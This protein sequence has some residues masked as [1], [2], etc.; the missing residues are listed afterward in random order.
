[1]KR[2][3]TV[4]FVLAACLGMGRTIANAASFTITE[5]K[6][7]KERIVTVTNP[8]FS[9]DFTTQGGRIR[10]FTTLPDKKNWTD[11]SPGIGGFF[12]DRDVRT[13]A[14]YTL[15]VKK[16]AMSVELLFANTDPLGIVWK[17]SFIVQDNSPS[18]AFSYALTS[19]SKKSFSYETMVRN[20]IFPAGNKVSKDSFLCFH[21]AEGIQQIRW[22]DLWR[23][24]KISDQ[25]IYN[26][27]YPWIALLDKTSKTGIVFSFEKVDK[28]YFWTKGNRATI[29][30]AFPKALM[31]PKKS[32]SFRGTISLV[33]G[34]DTV[35]YASQD[36]IAAMQPTSSE[37]TL[38]LLTLSR[39]SEPTKVRTMLYTPD[40]E[41]AINPIET[42]LPR[43]SDPSLPITIQIPWKVE[44]NKSFIASQELFSGKTKIA[45][46]ETPWS[47]SG[48]TLS[49]YRHPTRPL[50][51][52]RI[53]LH[54]LP[55]DIKRG[56][57]CFDS[58]FAETV[59]SISRLACDIGKEEQEWVRLGISAFSDLG[60]TSC[61]IVKSDFPGTIEVW[62]EEN[63][64][65][66]P[67]QTASLPKGTDT[68]FWMKIS[69]A[70]VPAGRYL[71]LLEVS[72]LEA[73][74]SQIEIDIKVWDVTLPKEKRLAC[75]FFHSSIESIFLY[76]YP[77]KPQT[78]WPVLWEKSLKILQDSGQNYFEFYPRAGVS[79]KLIT[80]AKREGNIP[81]LDFSK[82]DP[83]IRTARK[84]GC[85]NAVI[86]YIWQI[87]P[88]LPENFSSLSSQEQEEISF[89][90]LT[91][92]YNRL[93]YHGFSRIFYYHIDEL[94]PAKI[95]DVCA[96]M[97]RIRNVCPEIEFAGS[98]FAST[99]LPK[100]QQV[101]PYLGWVAPYSVSDAIF[102]WIEEGKVP[103]PPNAIVAT[104]FSA[105]A[106][107]GTYLQSRMNYW[108]AWK[109]N[110]GGCQ[111]YGYSTFYPNEKYNAVY[112]GDEG[113]VLS[114]VAIGFADGSDDYEYLRM[115]NEK[116]L[117]LSKQGNKKAAQRLQKELERVVAPQNALLTWEYSSHAS[118]VYPVLRGKEK[119]L[120]E[121]K[122]IILKLLTSP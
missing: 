121:A 79:D 38:S 94:D 109:R 85:N 56:Y 26:P 7:E 3:I 14:D 105:Q 28:L 59:A 27:V 46:Y 22:L 17:K 19:T 66:E 73:A 15:Q 53:A 75:T 51:E 49:S 122:Q 117:A 1:M 42:M 20:F 6:E 72:P 18:I 98:G 95:N 91:Q 35:S 99:S 113:P 25:W 78:Q 63:N 84:Y 30:W 44:E 93:K 67:V 37:T 87:K 12:D 101:G 102:D 106:P 39:R 45:E 4:C 103:L 55:E 74:P 88:W 86:R 47:P 65:I 36:L 111:I 60:L 52:D 10:S 70:G 31:Q 104:Q 40:R 80:V 119:D 32:F 108:R 116:I 34:F 41:E 5:S 57:F 97:E 50:A 13:M 96:K 76:L 110:L 21:S 33:Q 2:V 24:K 81:T 92:I 120:R 90:L 69:S 100:M 48:K 61:K 112:A 11:W 107:T 71:A 29:E 115:L 54:L 43:S 77:K 23:K 62:K 9:V 114:P 82:W 89:S 8:F 58:A 83:Y 64:R 118:F 68:G 16:R